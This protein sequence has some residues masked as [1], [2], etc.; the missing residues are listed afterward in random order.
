MSTRISFR[1][2]GAR[3][4]AAV[5]TVVAIVTIAAPAGAQQNLGR[6]DMTWRWDGPV[7]NGQWLRVFNVNGAM[8]VTASSD[9]NVHVRAEKRVRSGGDPTTV[10]FDVERD[11]DGVSIC[12]LWTDDATCDEHGARNN[13]I[14][15]GQWDRRQNVEVVFQ[16]QVPSGVRASMNTVNG[17]LNISRVAGEV[18]ANT[19]NGGVQVR[20]VGAAVN[21]RTVNGDIR[22]D[23]RGGPVSA[24]TV[25]GSIDATMASQGTA[26]MRFRSVN[27]GIDINAPDALNADVELSTVNGSIDSKYSLNYDRRRRHAEGTVGR[28]GPSLLASTV[29]GSVTLH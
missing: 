23:T 20:D 17:E 6:N 1:A 19:V 25:N 2:R 4:L 28:G 21:A 18:R 16:V 10:H 15:T 13:N 7:S 24:E 14:H 27:G 3:T 29:N 26:D 11:G 9:A 5:A 8:N 12:A 22:V